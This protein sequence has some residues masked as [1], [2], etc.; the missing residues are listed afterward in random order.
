MVYGGCRFRG[1]GW[2]WGL[3]STVATPGA[4]FS[5]HVF[6]IQICL[7]SPNFLQQSVFRPLV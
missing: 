5:A 7:S 3:D 2:G 6:L 1:L 4:D